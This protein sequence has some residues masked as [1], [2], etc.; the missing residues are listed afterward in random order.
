MDAAK[1]AGMLGAPFDPSEVKFKPQTV[2]GNRALATPFVD[3]RVVQDRLDDVLGVMGWQDRYE[4][5]PDGS[6]VCSLSVRLGSEWVTKTDVGGQS[7][8][9]DEGD[10]RKS[11]FSDALKRAAVKFGVGRYLYRLRPQWCDYD[12]AKRQFVRPPQLPADALPTPPLSDV[13]VKV[14]A[15]LIRESEADITAF[16]AYFGASELSEVPAARFAEAAELL[17]RKVA[18]KEG[19]A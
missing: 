7:G 9:P 6:V 11:A 10:R 19:K 18:K 5:M 1:L 3:A 15:G 2:S 12:P 13:Q 16:C 14:L 4:S 8:Q 17:R